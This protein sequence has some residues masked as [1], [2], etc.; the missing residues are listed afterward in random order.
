MKKLGFA[1]LILSFVFIITFGGTL[2]AYLDPPSLV[3]ILG[4]FFAL[5]LSTDN[6]SHFMKS[7]KVLSGYD[8]TNQELAHCISAVELSI[9]GLV[10]SGVIGFVFG[11]VTMLYYLDELMKIGPALATA[12][13]TLFYGVVL[14][15]FLLVILYQLRAIVNSKVSEE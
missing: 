9:R 14:S 1:L 4:I 8:Y 10:F 11:V 15:V 13:L 5:L 2:S 12:M 6:L 7:F 3:F